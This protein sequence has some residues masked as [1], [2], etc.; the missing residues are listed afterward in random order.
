[1]AHKR[2][3]TSDVKQSINVKIEEQNKFIEILKY[4]KISTFDLPN[5]CLIIVTTSNLENKISVVAS[6]SPAGVYA[7]VVAL[8]AA[9]PDHSKI[10]VVSQDGHWYYYN[11]G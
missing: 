10:Y 9:D 11:S 5:N 2:K 3:F 7:T 6:G 4:H 8:T 1:M